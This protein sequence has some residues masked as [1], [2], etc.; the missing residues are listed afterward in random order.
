MSPERP[1]TS[2]LK[3]TALLNVVDTTGI[4]EF[5][6]GLVETGYGLIAAGTTAKTLQ[7]E[8]VPFRDITSITG[9][10][11]IC[12]GRV[13]LTH[14]RLFAGILADRADGD[15]MRDLDRES[16]PPIDLVAVNLYPLAQVLQSGAADQ[17]EMLDFLDVGGGALLRAA[18]RNLRHVITLCDPGD[19]ASVLETLRRGRGLTLERSQALAAKAFYYVS[20]YD[21]T[22]AQ[23]LSHTMESLPDEFI[24]SLKKASDL[25]FGENPH[26][27]A[28]LYSRSGARPW[29]LNAAALI[30][31][32]PLNYNHYLSMDRAVELAA[33]FS[34]PA[35]AIIK[36]GVPAGAAAGKT[37]GEAARL[38]YESDPQGCTG[39]VAAFNKPVD[40]DA[41][42][43]L[44]P[45]YLECIVAPE[46]SGEALRLLRAKKDIRLVQLPSL[47]LSPK[48]SDMKTVSGGM[49]IQDKDHPVASEVLKPVTRSEPSELE[50][51]ALE[52]AWRVCKHAGTHAAILARGTVTLGIGNGQSSRLDAVRLALVKSQE[53]HPVVSPAIPMVLASDGVLG[54]QEIREAAEC[55]IIGVIQ[56]GGSSE[57]RET[58]ATADELG[59]T[60]VFTGV[61]HFRH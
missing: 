38:A 14:H 54:P 10:P 55:G 33:E 45:E 40:E 59:M 13:R 57:D 52:F 9:Q 34:D 47:L 48:E 60:M 36:Y 29:G 31:G 11:D 44:A 51:I 41:A 39:G 37:L 6:R 43:V 24:V 53:R 2:R 21:S 15:Q 32:K 26:Q 4:V 5:A 25:R 49:L 28:A 16:I 22:A 3:K 8:S 18:A 27:R 35:C 19:Y 56:P 7:G 23:F 42:K 20:Y 1:D 12:A 30:H 58:I 46:F 50:R 17:R 61:R